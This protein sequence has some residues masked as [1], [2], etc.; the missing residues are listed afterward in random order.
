MVNIDKRQPSCAYIMYACVRLCVSDYFSHIQ[1]NSAA[2]NE[3]T[4]PI[5]RTSPVAFSSRGRLPDLP[6]SAV[7]NNFTPRDPVALSGLTINYRLR[8]GKG[9]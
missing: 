1:A 6:D 3:H 9:M 4:D 5:P 8:R 2:Q 7:S